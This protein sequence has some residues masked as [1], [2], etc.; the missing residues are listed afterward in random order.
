MLPSR[1][2]WEVARAV[3]PEPHPAVAVGLQNSI[4][5]AGGANHAEASLV[6]RL[7]SIYVECLSRLP[8]SPGKQVELLSWC[9]EIAKLWINSI[10]SNQH[11][12]SYDKAA[13]LI[14]GCTE[15]LR[16]GRKDQEAEAMDVLSELVQ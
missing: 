2:V 1:N 5:F 16:L 4:G 10:V 11:R 3:A 9:L 7:E 6:T 12:V 8:L 15:V 13:V 14:A